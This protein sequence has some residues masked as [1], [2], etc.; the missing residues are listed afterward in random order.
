MESRNRHIFRIGLLM[1]NTSNM[2]FFFDSIF[3]SICPIYIYG[4]GK[5]SQVITDF[6]NKYNQQNRI[7]AYVV[8]EL[9]SNPSDIMGVPVYE[10]DNIRINK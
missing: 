10:L 2:T 4:A 3:R 6:L 8:Q 7:S 1:I 9:G 5:R